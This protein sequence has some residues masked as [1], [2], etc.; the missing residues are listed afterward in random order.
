[1]KVITYSLRSGRS[2]ADDYYRTIG[3]FTDVVLERAGFVFAGL[4]D[5]YDEY[6]AQHS[7]PGRG[8]ASEYY[9]DLLVMGVFWRVY[10]PMA[11][12][13]VTE[14]A[15]A[16]LD[17]PHSRT[18]RPAL[19][20][21]PDVSDELR[22]QGEKGD[23][24]KVLT[25]PRLTALAHWMANSG[26]FQEEARRLRPWIGFLAGM[27]QAEANRVLATIANF[28]AS[29]DVWSRQA[30]GSFT[31]YVQRFL[32]VTYPSYH[33]R[34]DALFCGRTQLEYH[35]SMVGSEIL[36]RT[37]RAAFEA[38][39]EK[40]VV[41]P[42][43][44]RV[45]HDAFCKGVYTEQGIVCQECTD[46]CQ[47]NL[48]SRLGQKYGF[49]VHIIPD[50]LKAFVSRQPGRSTAVVGV[51]CALTNTAGGWETRRLGIPAQGVLLDYCGCTYHWDK[52]GVTTEVSVRRL[53][54]VLG[55]QLEEGALDGAD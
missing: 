11:G 3:D 35:L 21:P 25:M 53:L 41:L 51:S 9:L 39:D 28:A 15:E 33:G 48:I 27:P 55:I 31:D 18:T 19:D 50:D 12:E 1:M 45:Q 23:P 47:V 20:L 8:Q 52:K 42:P 37:G 2:S 16:A 46:G 10:S 22:W 38:A 43:C 13:A 34:E 49:A 44:M 24:N 6:L 14:A 17:T 26:E 4:V 36:N 40:V 30:L 5:R 32:A 7:L 29:F 54:E